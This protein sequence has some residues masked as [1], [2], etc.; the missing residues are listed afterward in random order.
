MVVNVREYQS[1]A[2]GSNRI[3]YEKTACAV[4]DFDPIFCEQPDN[5]LIERMSGSRRELVVPYVIL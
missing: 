3:I 1:H 5:T 2:D 4:S